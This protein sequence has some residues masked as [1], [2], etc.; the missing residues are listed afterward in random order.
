M[1]GDRKATHPCQCE[2]YDG[3]KQERRCGVGQVQRCPDRISWQLL[4]RIDIQLEVLAVGYC[5]LT[6]QEASHLSATVRDRIRTNLDMCPTR[7]ST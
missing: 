7:F 3:P 1:I 6:S 5:E 4:D 2:L